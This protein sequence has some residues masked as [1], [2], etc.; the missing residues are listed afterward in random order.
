[1][2]EMENCPHCGESLVPKVTRPDGCVCAESEW[3]DPFNLPPVCANYQEERSSGVCANCEHDEQCHQ[4]ANAEVCGAEGIRS[5]A[6][7]GDATKGV[8]DD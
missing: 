2:S 7:L 6:T 4:P 1:M 5:T 8:N 3:R